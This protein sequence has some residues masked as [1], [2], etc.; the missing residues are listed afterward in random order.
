MISVA[1]VD[2]EKYVREGLQLLVD[3]ADGMRCV[4]TFGD[5]GEAIEGIAG[6]GPNV[7][8]MDIGLPDMSGIECLRSIKTQLPAVDII[9]LSCKEDDESIFHSLEAGA[10]GYLT[11]SVFPTRL[12]DAIHEVSNG[13]APMSSHI[14]R[15]VIAT[16]NR[17]PKANPKLTKREDEVLN[18]LCE[19]KNY[20]EIADQM[21]ISPHTV[22]YHLKNIYKK[23]QVNSMH[24][25]VIKAS[26][27]RKF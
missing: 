19:G 15:R 25:A 24:E 23:L 27:R 18:L 14:A 2:D 10:C 6:L 5:A 16:F 26:G 8:L 4:G 1:I 11:K 21:F 17:I 9:M 13:G 12:I 22:N 3:K 7:V 20:K